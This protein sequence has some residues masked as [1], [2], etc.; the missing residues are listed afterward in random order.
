MADGQKGGRNGQ[1][2]TPREGEMEEGQEGQQPRPMTRRQMLR[3]AGMAGVA[4]GAAAVAPGALGATPASRTGLPVVGT[5]GGAINAASGAAIDAAASRAATGFAAQVI[6]RPP[7]H[8]TVAEFELLDAMVARI[9]PA[10]DL[11]PGAREAGVIYY[12]DREAGGALAEQKE[13]YQL[14]LAALERYSRYS[15]GR[16]FTELS[17]LEQDSLLID[18]QGGSATATGAGFAG[19]SAAFFNMVRSHTLQ[20]MFGDPYYGGNQGY[21]GWDLLR[22]PGVRSG[23]NAPDQARLEAD[24][25]APSRR[26]AYDH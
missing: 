22:Y 1:D 21:I 19:S 18:V 3:H 20:G 11:G 10:D 7:H 6:P 12:I 14:G 24:D 16:P 8:F 17:E 13:A 23:L 4:A 26:S 15:R 9:I 2:G 5:S 25:L